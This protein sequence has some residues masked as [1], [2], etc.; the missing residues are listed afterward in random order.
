MHH[1]ATADDL[2]LAR[3][4]PPPHASALRAQMFCNVTIPWGALMKIYHFLQTLHSISLWIKRKRYC[5]SCFNWHTYMRWSAFSLASKWVIQPSIRFSL[6]WSRW[7]MSS[8][9]EKNCPVL[10]GWLK[11][12]Q[13]YNS[14]RIPHTILDVLS[15][16]LDYP[17]ILQTLRPIL[18]N[19]PTST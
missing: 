9:E 4:P 1:F 3:C 10:S 19:V 18:W 11:V 8:Y 16:L 12:H 13:T 6:H 15:L 7:R 2:H 17:Q 14:L 5:E